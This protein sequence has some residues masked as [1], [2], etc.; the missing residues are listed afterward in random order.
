MR[1]GTITVSNVGIYE[2]DGVYQWYLRHF[3]VWQNSVITS[4]RAVIALGDDPRTLLFDY[5]DTFR[6]PVRK[7]PAVAFNTFWSDPY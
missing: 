4:C 3:P 2:K 7:T 5:I 1:N 6:L